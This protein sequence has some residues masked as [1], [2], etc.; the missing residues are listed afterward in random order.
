MFA[1][2]RSCLQKVPSF[3]DGQ[4]SILTV[5]NTCS[6][7]RYNCYNHSLH[8]RNSKGFITGKHTMACQADLS[9]SQDFGCCSMKMTS[10]S[11]ISWALSVR[12]LWGL[13]C[14]CVC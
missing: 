7:L 2:L 13:V 4:M 10:L 5:F 1:R 6:T 11:L 8:R 14:V 9:S 3:C 12:S